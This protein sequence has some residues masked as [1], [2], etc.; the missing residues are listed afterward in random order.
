MAFVRVCALSAV[1]PGRMLR[2][3][4]GAEPVALCNVGGVFHAVDDTCTHSN[5]SL[6][7]GDLE[8]DVLLCPLHNARFCVRTGRVLAPPAPDPLRVYPVR[9]DGD[10]VLVDLQ[11][12]AVH[13]DVTA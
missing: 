10:D 7:D 9:I 11:A 6:C 13:P 2:I 1:P 4:S 3:E 12:G 5:W 8:G